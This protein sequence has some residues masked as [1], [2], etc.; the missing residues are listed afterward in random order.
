MLTTFVQCHTVVMDQLVSYMC[1]Y[2]DVPQRN[3][4][5]NASNVS[6]QSQY[7]KYSYVSDGSSHAT[8]TKL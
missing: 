8:K 1:T 6:D 2:A 3:F 7:L 5:Q 4:S